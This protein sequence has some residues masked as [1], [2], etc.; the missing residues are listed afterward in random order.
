MVTG[1]TYIWEFIVE[2]DFRKEFERCYGVNGLWVQLFQRAPGYQDT[3]LLRDRTHS[4]R[5]L[6]IDRWQ[7]E[8]AYKNFR[9]AFSR[10]YE[11]LD[12]ACSRLTLR[13]TSLG[14]FEAI[15]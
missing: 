8:E 7:S 4:E 5:Y 13:E 3:L 11:Q 15:R 9:K 10:E 12:G 6:T 14:T 2:A 1:Y